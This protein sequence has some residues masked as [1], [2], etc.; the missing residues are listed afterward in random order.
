MATTDRHADRDPG[1]RPRPVRR[2]ARTGRDPAVPHE[3]PRPAL[4][5]PRRTRPG[6]CHGE[7]GRPGHGVYD[8]TTD[9]RPYPRP[10]RRRALGH[11]L[12]HRL[13][14]APRTTSSASTSTPSPARTPRPPCANWRCATS[15]RSRTPSS[16]SP[17]AAAAICGS[18]D[19]RTSS[20]PTRRAA[21]RRASTSAAPAATSSAPA[22]APPTA[23]TAPPPA[24][25]TSPARPARRALLRLLT[26]PPRVH[27][28]S[29]G[30]CGPTRPGPGPVRAGRTRGP[31]QHPSVLGRLP[32]LRERPR[33]QPHERPRGSRRL[34]TGLTEREARSTIASAARLTQRNDAEA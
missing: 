32:R 3:A 5:A 8:A 14:T 33:R 30:T 11:R 27:H 4:P 7:C 26:P 31:A 9:P 10:L 6:P 29:T 18:P 20:S 24:P 19:R 25:P 1:P 22:R 21:S 12:R 17:P 15:S 23:S 2:R 34:R 13:R 16:C 28:P